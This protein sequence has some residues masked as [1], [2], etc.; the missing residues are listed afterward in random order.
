MLNLEFSRNN[1]NK[2]D[3]DDLKVTD[4]ILFL[5]LMSIWV[6]AIIIRVWNI[7]LLPINGDEAIYAMLLRSAPKLWWGNLVSYIIWP[8]FFIF[9]ES[10]VLGRIIITILSSLP[11]ILL[12]FLRRELSNSGV[13]FSGLYI[14]FCPSWVIFSR[15]WVISNLFPTF[16]LLVI[17]SIT[18]YYRNRSWLS[19]LFIGISIGLSFSVYPFSIVLLFVLISFILI[20]TNLY[21]LEQDKRPYK[22][23]LV[24]IKKNWKNYVTI[25][26]VSPILPLIA[27]GPN[28]F[29]RADPSS[30]LSPQYSYWFGYSFQSVGGIQYYLEY[31]LGTLHGIW[32]FSLGI[33]GCLLTFFWFSRNDFDSHYWFRTF[34]VFWFGAMF[35]VLSLWSLKNLR[36]ALF[37]L[38]PLSLMSGLIA[39][40]LSHIIFSLIEKVIKN[41]PIALKSVDLLRKTQKCVIPVILLSFFLLNSFILLSSQIPGITG[42]VSKDFRAEAANYAIGKLKGLGKTQ[43]TQVGV[44]SYPWEW[45]FRELEEDE[46]IFYYSSHF[47]KSLLLN[48]SVFVFSGKRTSS[49]VLDYENYLSSISHIIKKSFHSPNYDQNQNYVTVYCIIE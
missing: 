21:C 30:V 28:L 42:T 9:G 15:L 22:H 36:Y 10:I 33:L 17:I 49:E 39:K 31:W 12:F 34:A 23:I 32:F 14:A 46:F 16:N 13:V 26:L 48:Q 45:F 41:A 5:I 27:I 43:I 4:K 3:I 25:V 29:F 38:L 44:S 19:S 2:Y 20:T 18:S 7:N 8:F 37:F 6:V 11:I 40:F 47:N 35:I 1:E 24:E